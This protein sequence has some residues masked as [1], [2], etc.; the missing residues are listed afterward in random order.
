MAYKHLN[1]KIVLISITNS[2]KRICISFSIVCQYA[3]LGLVDY[4]NNWHVAR[5]VCWNI[6]HSFS[7]PGAQSFAIAKNMP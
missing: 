3:D 6:K 2:E 1:L 7:K 5:S 4:F